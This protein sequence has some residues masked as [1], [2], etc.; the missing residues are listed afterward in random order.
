MTSIEA[1]EVLSAMVRQIDHGTLQPDASLDQDTRN[2]QAICKAI[3]TIT[4]APAKPY[5]VFNSSLDCAILAQYQ[6]RACQNC[7]IET[8]L[9]QELVI[10]E[11]RKELAKYLS[12]SAN[13][14]PNPDT[15]PVS[16]SQVSDAV[17]DAMNEIYKKFGLARSLG[18]FNCYLKAGETL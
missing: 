16:I 7:K 14:T 4:K 8:Q 13:R 6:L 11:A 17:N 1:I 2:K 5:W 15:C 3:E 18:L 9:Q 12:S 10:R